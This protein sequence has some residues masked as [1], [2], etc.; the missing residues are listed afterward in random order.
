MAGGSGEL[1]QTQH[2]DQCTRGPLEVSQPPFSPKIQLSWLFLLEI[3]L[4]KCEIHGTSNE[5]CWHD[6]ND[7][8]DARPL[9]VSFPASVH[10][11]LQIF[12]QL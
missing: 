8:L 11:V 9:D 12:S 6:P 5:L 2:L 10:Q 4:A 3:G 1:A 7:Y